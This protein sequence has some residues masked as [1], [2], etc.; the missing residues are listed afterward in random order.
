[1]NTK[2]VKKTEIK[3]SWHHIDVKGKVLGRISSEIAQL[4]IGKHKPYFTPNLDCGDYV[5]ITNAEKIKVTGRKAKQKIYSR[6]SNYP[7]G[8]KQVTFK[9]QLD[10][11]PTKIITRAVKNMLPKNRLQSERM[12]RLK[13]FA[14]ENHPYLE[15]LNK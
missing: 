4:L 12:S 11:D 10:K 5:V 2:P 3:R 13:V 6:H 14:G 15:K 7:G 1:M 9:Q 8:L